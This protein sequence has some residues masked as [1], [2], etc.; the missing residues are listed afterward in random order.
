MKKL[1]L[2]L[3]ITTLCSISS[4]ANTIIHVHEYTYSYSQTAK[5]D[6]LKN[7]IKENKLGFKLIGMSYNERAKTVTYSYSNSKEIEVT[8]CLQAKYQ[9]KF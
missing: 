5:G 2:S 7:G 6:H 9:I 8:K 1:M 4:F 3:A